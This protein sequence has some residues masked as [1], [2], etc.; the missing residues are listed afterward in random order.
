MG[1]LPR[2]SALGAVG[3]A[4]G[5]QTRLVLHSVY[6]TQRRSAKTERLRPYRCE[7][8]PRS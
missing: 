7:D 8:E 6:D 2:E 5:S 3:I 4:Q 1:Y